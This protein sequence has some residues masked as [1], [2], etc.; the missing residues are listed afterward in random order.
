MIYPFVM[1]QFVFVLLM[2][3]LVELM[4]LQMH[5]KNHQYKN[6]E[7]IVYMIFISLRFNYF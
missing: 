2:Y 3:L 5:L 7:M 4:M 6:E 1:K